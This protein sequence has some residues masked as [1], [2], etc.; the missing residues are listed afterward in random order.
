M[1]HLLADDLSATGLFT[2]AP[3]I[4]KQLFHILIREAS[5]YRKVYEGGAAVKHAIPNTRNTGRERD[6]REFVAVEKRIFPNARHAIRDRHAPEGVTLL[7]RAL[8][9]ARDTGRERDTREF[10]AVG[11]SATLNAR[12]AIRDRNACKR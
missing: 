10:V 9:N 8:P 3:K 4:R 7:K 12:H 6:T 2:S 1:P 11:K 5:R